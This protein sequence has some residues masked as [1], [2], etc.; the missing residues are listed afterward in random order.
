MAITAGGA[1]TALPR[2]VRERYADF[3]ADNAVM[4]GTSITRRPDAISFDYLT[5]HTVGPIALGDTSAGIVAWVWKARAT[6]TGVYVA[7]ENATRDG[8]LP[9]TL[10][11][12]YGGAPIDEMDFCFDQNGQPIV[13]ADRAGVLWIYYPDITLGGYGFRSFGAGRTPRVVLD[14]PLD[15]NG[16]DVLVFY[17]DTALG[18]VYR[19]QRERYATV[20]ATTPS[21]ANPVYTPPEPVMNYGPVRL[22]GRETFP[23]A[24]GA[25]GGIAVTLTQGLTKPADVNDNRPTDRFGENAAT[26]E[27]ATLT[28][29]QMI[30]G[31]AVDVADYSG[32]GF[33]H[34]AGSVS[35]YRGALH[36]AE[37]PVTAPTLGDPIGHATFYF[38]DGFDK[39]V[40][41]APMAGVFRN[42]RVLLSAAQLAV[43]KANVCVHGPVA[44]TYTGDP[45]VVSATVDG[46]TIDA[47]APLDILN[48]VPINPASLLYALVP[49]T[50]TPGVFRPMAWADIER[51]YGWRHD[52]DGTRIQSSA[53][54]SPF[55]HPQLVTGDNRNQQ[56][57][58]LVLT[59]STAVDG[60]EIE[61]AG[62]KY[63]GNRIIAYNAA[64]AVLAS[65]EPTPP[66]AFALYSNAYAIY[67]VGIK[68]LRLV[69]AP[70]DVLGVNSD[71]SWTQLKFKKAGDLPVDGGGSV[72]T[73]PQVFPPAPPIP[74]TDV[75]LEDAVRT[76]DGRVTVIYSV[77][78]AATGAYSFGRIDTVLYPY[79][80]PLDGEF[81]LTQAAVIDAILRLLVVDYLA[82]FD[83]EGVIDGFGLTPFGIAAL[84]NASGT[85]VDKA[86]PWVDEAITV[87]MSVPSAILF[88]VIH[89]WS[90]YYDL[91][92]VTQVLGSNG[93][94]LVQVVFDH[95]EPYGSEGMTAGFGVN[96]TGNSLIAAP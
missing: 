56:S 89:D 94:A 16:S 23:L 19:Q 88:L 57:T 92:G 84:I 70:S 24:H 74:K 55:G 37:V 54:G 33:A 65:I 81:M 51:P 73:P 69:P 34:G 66:R 27:A 35:L 90:Q 77:R 22:S 15:V 28:F 13:A 91:E 31:L 95:D 47:R 45:T 1:G 38:A 17:V 40:F 93:G 60:I 86:Q 25:I 59:F 72:P 83:A 26:H 76:P 96:S 36:V 58:D 4:V 30:F 71:V 48:G 11:F 9:E 62:T 6:T 5:A 49:H 61:V 50:N 63:Y 80:A 29:S 18:I 67:A 41:T 43:V 78:D 3:L 64:G 82:P 32:T 20:H 12:N 53:I 21:G 8:W 85:I 68:T 10:L 44:F 7:R 14:D 52:A 42:L 87:S 2:G 79:H 75:F 46:I 39:L